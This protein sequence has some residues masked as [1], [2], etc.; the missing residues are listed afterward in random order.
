MNSVMKFPKSLLLP[1]KRF[2]ESEL[3]RLKRREKSLGKE[4]PFNDEARLV[5]NSTEE[6][7]GEQIGHFESTVKINFV[8]KQVIE[9]R[10]A[11]TRMK[12]GKYGIC[13]SCG[14]MIDTDRLAVKPESTVCIDCEKEVES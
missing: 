14:R 10:R 9:F 2:L 3:V 8:K 12:L 6:D 5:E 7:V 13:E 4:D 1:I 11:L